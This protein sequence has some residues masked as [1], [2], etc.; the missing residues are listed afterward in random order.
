MRREEHRPG[1]S[2]TVGFLLVATVR[3]AGR[4]NPAGSVGEAGPRTEG[5]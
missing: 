3:R 2:L 5:G 1:R 4:D